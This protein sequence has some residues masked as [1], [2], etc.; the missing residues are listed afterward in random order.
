MEHLDKDL[1]NRLQAQHQERDEAKIKQPLTDDILERYEQ[2]IQA[3]HTLRQIIEQQLPYQWPFRRPATQKKEASPS[4]PPFD[5][6]E[7]QNPKTAEKAL[8]AVDETISEVH[9]LY[10]WDYDKVQ[11]EWVAK[12]QEKEIYRFRRPLV[13]KLRTTFTEKRKGF[14][15]F[16]YLIVLPLLIGIL[17]IPFLPSDRYRAGI[18]KTFAPPLPS[19]QYRLNDQ[20]MKLLDEW[21][22]ISR[23]GQNS[24][25]DAFVLVNHEELKQIGMKLIEQGNL[26]NERG[27]VTEARTRFIWASHIGTVLQRA[28][29]DAELIIQVGN[30][31]QLPAEQ[32]TVK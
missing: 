2:L 8:E 26:W 13:K 24:Y 9:K 11:R 21:Y 22:D 4:P 31:H 16:F 32:T 20:E 14:P 19:Q 3:Q 1:H 23:S 29:N 28:V 27:N 30:L 15:G 6:L 18:S 25:V 10:M 17:T 5:W 7:K 12:Q